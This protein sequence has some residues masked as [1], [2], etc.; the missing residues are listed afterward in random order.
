L[1]APVG[2]Q[3]EQSIGELFGRLADDGKAY[4]RAE[5]GLYKT[6]AA[7]RAGQA[8]NGAIALAAALLLGNAALIVLLVGLSLELAL[9]VGP[10]IAGII[11]SLVLLGAAFLLVRYGAGKMKALSGDAEEQAALRTGERAA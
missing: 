11:V 8:R 9:V 5:V 10:A 4:V 3:A 1:D 2:N 7:R 6:I